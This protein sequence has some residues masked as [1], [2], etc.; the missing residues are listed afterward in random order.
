MLELMVL[1]QTDLTQAIMSAR[2]RDGRG[3]YLRMYT[4]PPTNARANITCGST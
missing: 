1:P 3:D 4:I 2:N